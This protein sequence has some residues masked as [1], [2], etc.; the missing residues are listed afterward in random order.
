MPAGCELCEREVPA[1]T[2][3]HLYP[4]SKGRRKGLKPF[5]LPTAD[6]CPDCHK[7]IHVLFPN[8]VLAE[9]LTSVDALKREPEMERFLEWLR[10]QPGDRRIRVRS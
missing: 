8:R 4:I 10:K 9:R 7:Q 2:I 5:E 1:T 3:H 6:L